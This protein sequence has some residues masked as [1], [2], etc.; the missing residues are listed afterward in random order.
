M[1]DLKGYSLILASGS[2][3]RQELLNACRVP[4]SIQPSI[5]EEIY[6]SS[7]ELKSIP[8][9]LANLKSLDILNQNNEQSIVIGADTIVLLNDTVLGKPKDETQAFQ[10][11][12]DLSDNKH[13]VYTGVSI[14]SHDTQVSFSVHTS[15][16]FDVI[17]NSEINRY[18]AECNPLDKAGAYGIQDWIGSKYIKKIEGDYFNVMGFPISRVFIELKKFV[19]DLNVNSH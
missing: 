12:S 17:S 4:F 6:P 2:P 16:H 11:L 10:M 7:L 13:D 18:I 3:R 15:I 5:K 9:F 14:H 1:I 8:E 19:R